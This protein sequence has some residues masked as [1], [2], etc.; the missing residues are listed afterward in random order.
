MYSKGVSEE[1]TGRLLGEMAA[2]RDEIVIATKLFYP[3]SARPNRGGLSRKRIFD[4]VHDSLRRLG[5]DYIDLY[6]IHRWDPTTPIEETMEA[7]DDVVKAG[8]VRYLGASSM[9]A[10]QFAK[11]QHA[12]DLG[13]QTRFVSMQNHYNLLY[14]EE[15]REMMPFCRE[16]GI[17]VL[18]WSPTARGYLARP[19]AEAES[20]TR[21][22]WDDFSRR[23]YDFPE[24]EAI[25][26]AVGEVA[27][28]RGVSRAQV[29]L[30][31]LLSREG[32]TAPIVGATKKGHLE[33]AAASVDLVLSLEETQRLEAPY[34]P[35]EVLGHS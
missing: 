24:R 27:G 13:G 9:F 26:R 12:A 15:E 3:M 4:S 1:V 10:Y 34:R 18:P 2:R 23:L 19:P 25:Q 32:V 30:A 14:R 8:Y 20:T 11:A 7:L 6:Q 5:T 17:G 28:G 33:D 29:A 35:R 31:W 16:D 22:E 21:G